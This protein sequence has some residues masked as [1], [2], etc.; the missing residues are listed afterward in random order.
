MIAIRIGQA[1]CTVHNGVWK[2]AGPSANLFESLLTA[3]TEE[4]TELGGPDDPDH[5]M[6]I[7]RHVARVFGARI[8]ST[9]KHETPEVVEDGR[10]Y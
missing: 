1:S 8:I 5:D 7:S 2:C 9:A 6:S 3:E 10:V 4:M